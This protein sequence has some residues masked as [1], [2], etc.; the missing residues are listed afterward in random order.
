VTKS[1]GLFACFPV[2]AAL[3][4]LDPGSLMPGGGWLTTRACPAAGGLKGTC[5]AYSPGVTADDR[6]SHNRDV[7]ADDE[8]EFRPS[9]TGPSRYSASASA[10]PG[11]NGD[12]PDGLSA[13]VAYR[14]LGP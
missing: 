4:A 3:L 2:P 10:L 6:L 12:T 14:F 9:I 1:V 8:F 5:F 13:G 7:R 11:N